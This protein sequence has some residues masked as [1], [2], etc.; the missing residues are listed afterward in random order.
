M[1][2]V[3]T[4]TGALDLDDLRAKV[5]EHHRRVRSGEHPTEVDDTDPAEGALRRHAPGL[6]P[7]RYTVVV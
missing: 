5:A 7:R 6:P 2:G 1:S 3:I 4:G